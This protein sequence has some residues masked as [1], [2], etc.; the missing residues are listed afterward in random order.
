MGQLCEMNGDVL[1]LQTG[2]TDWWNLI[3][4]QKGGAG[5]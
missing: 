3:F 2:E 5:N 1:E 4:G